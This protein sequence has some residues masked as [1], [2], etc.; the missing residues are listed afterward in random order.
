MTTKHKY[1]GLAELLDGGAE[2]AKAEAPSQDKPEAAAKG[3]KGSKSSARS[4]ASKSG[5]SK[6]GKAGGAS[7]EKAVE[8]LETLETTTDDEP[9]NG[10]KRDIEHI[11][12]SSEDDDIVISTSRKGK[13]KATTSAPR[14]SR[15]G[16]GL[17]PV[18][19]PRTLREEEE[20][21][22][23]DGA[24]ARQKWPVTS[25]KADTEPQEVSSDE[26]DGDAMD[27]DTED[28]VQVLKEAPIASP[29]LR[30]R[31]LKKQPPINAKYGSVKAPANETIE[32]RAERLRVQDD[33]DKLREIF[34][35]ND[36]T[37]DTDDE[38]VES[39]E[40][41]KLFLFQLP[42]LT[43]F[44]TDPNSAT[45]EIKPEPVPTTANATIDLDSIPNAPDGPIKP[46]PEADTR[47]KHTPQLD[48]LLTASEPLRLPAGVVGKL[49]VHKSGKVTLDW[50]GTDM[51][52][53]MGSE[54][55]FLQDVVLVRP[56]GPKGNEMDVD[57]DEDMGVGSRKERKGR[58][59]G[60]GHVRQKMVLIPDWAKLYD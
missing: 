29:E 46:D 20:Q 49:K 45:P 56:P 11:W 53:K 34:T 10:P 24:S 54:V 4:G 37:M 47:K 12:L 51:E 21:A 25:R 38:D 60:L 52:V 27:V 40:H 3:T 18:R 28:S 33:V 32:D 57:G 2:G 9:D 41:G 6:G 59:Y 1:E 8:T 31:I 19:A 13:Q 50:G 55:D 30:K 22:G 5:T 17:R 48:G 42:P 44:L 43:P 36:T 7:T 58:A 35:T 23:R 15:S 14:P 16:L 39:S 26:R